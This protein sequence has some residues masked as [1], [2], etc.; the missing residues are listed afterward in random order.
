MRS[1]VLLGLI[2]IAML[3]LAYAQE[4]ING[5]QLVPAGLQEAVEEQVRAKRQFGFGGYPGFGYG[6]YPG[7]G[8][9]GGYPGYGGGY[10]GYPGYG[11]GFGGFGGY[12][13]YG[14]YGRRYHHHGGFFG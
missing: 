10:R 7:F 8:G 3:S 6:G 11:G 12:G 5:D 2:G 14:G 9:I 4:N 13:G 1:L